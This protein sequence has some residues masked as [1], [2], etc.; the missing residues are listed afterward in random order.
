MRYRYKLIENSELNGKQPFVV[1]E[2]WGSAKYIK[3]WVDSVAKGNANVHAFDFPLKFTLTEMCNNSGNDFDISRLNHAGMIRNNE[4][5]ALPPDNVVTFV[6][7]HDT[8]KE[9]DKWITKDF[10]MAYAYILTHEGT[11]CIFYP[12]YFAVK[13]YDVNDHQQIVEAPTSL[14]DTISKL[15][16]IRK[17]YIGG[18]TVVLTETGNPSPEKVTKNVYVARRQGTRSTSGAI[19]VL[20]NNDTDTLSIN[21]SVN[22]QGF[23][24]LSDTQLVDAFSPTNKVKVSKDGRVT[25]IVQP[26]G[27]SIWVKE[28]EL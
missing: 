6:D 17:K 21:L 28:N 22:S 24:D 2:Y 13:Q 25:F 18:K 9:H 10:A 11:P 23:K 12:H 1:G 3:E 8:G 20:N 14:K 15:I 26:R 19:I 5:Y 27:F 7:N 4:G 16:K